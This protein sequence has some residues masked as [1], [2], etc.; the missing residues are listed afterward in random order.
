MA[1]R[2]V[3]T[4]AMTPALSKLKASQHQAQ[5]SKQADNLNQLAQAQPPMYGAG[6]PWGPY[7]FPSGFPA[8]GYPGYG[9]PPPAYGQPQAHE[10]TLS[11]TTLYARGLSIDMSEDQINEAFGRFG[12]IKSTRVQKDKI[13]GNFNGSVFVEFVHPS[14]AKLAQVQMDKKPLGERTI[15]VDFAKERVKPQRNT[16]QSNALPSA[17][18]YISGLPVEVEKDYIQSMFARFGEIEAIRLQ[19]PKSASQGKVAF[20]DFKMQES[21]T[22]AIDQMNGTPVGPG[23]QLKVSYATVKR[24]ND[25]PDYLYGDEPQAKKARTDMVNPYGLPPGASFFFFVSVFFLILLL[26]LQLVIQEPAILATHQHRMHSA[27]LWLLTMV[28]LKLIINEFSLGKGEL[29]VSCGWL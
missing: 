17:S 4:I 11:E 22:A 14:A 19:A 1:V 8:P 18:L 24:K 25:T 7:G 21:A 13:T 6:A 10:T 23:L 16:T 26:T 3:E 5:Q 2:L 20:L 28:L 12:P 9:Y 15:Y 27:I 29:V